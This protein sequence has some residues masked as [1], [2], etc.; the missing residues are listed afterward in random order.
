MKEDQITLNVLIL[1]LATMIVAIALAFDANFLSS[2][3][4]FLEGLIEFITISIIVIRFWWDYVM[5]RLE[6]PPKTT[7]FPIIDILILILISLIPF[8]LKQGF[9]YTSGLL[10]ALMIVWAFMT[11]RMISKN[12]EIDAQRIRRLRIDMYERI[13]AGLFLVVAS[14]FA[15]TNEL[16]AYIGLFLVVIVIIFLRN[17]RD[18]LKKK[19]VK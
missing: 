11:K 14:I 13:V 12:L 2:T 10:A 4:F 3:P 7:H 17:I 18:Y 8:V 9:F 6:F 15:I 5:D 1:E 19:D 16:L